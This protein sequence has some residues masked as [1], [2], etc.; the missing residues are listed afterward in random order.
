MLTT[1]DNF[2]F[3]QLSGEWGRQKREEKSSTGGRKALLLF[4]PGPLQSSQD[5]RRMDEKS[6]LGLFRT[7]V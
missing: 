2:L 3:F 7:F 5:L 1:P 6:Q 4:K